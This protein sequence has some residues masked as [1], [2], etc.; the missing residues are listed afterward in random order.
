M[1]LPALYAFPGSAEDWKA[2]TFNHAANHYD[3]LNAP[4]AA[5][6]NLAQYPLDISDFSNMGMW[7]YQHQ[8]MHNQVNALLKTQGFD[9]QTL[10]WQ[11]PDQL[12]DWLNLN[13]NEHVRISA[14]LGVQ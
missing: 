10:D 12:R 13:G 2:W 1:S 3:W 5:G 7:I 8:I 9:L 4:K 6:Q 14:A 11:D